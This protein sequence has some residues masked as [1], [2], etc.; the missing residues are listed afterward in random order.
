MKVTINLSDETRLVQRDPRKQVA[1]I[2][3]KSNKCR[4]LDFTFLDSRS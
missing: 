4:R 2:R 1:L 3:F